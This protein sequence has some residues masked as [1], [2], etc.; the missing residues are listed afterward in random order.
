MNGGS[1]P[2]GNWV[3]AEHHDLLE[4]VRLGGSRDIGVG[5]ELLVE[6]GQDELGRRGGG[7]CKALHLVANLFQHLGRGHTLDAGEG[8]FDIH[9]RKKLGVV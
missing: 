4:A 3:V 6:L 7:F 1:K 5:L 2:C 9:P 8:E